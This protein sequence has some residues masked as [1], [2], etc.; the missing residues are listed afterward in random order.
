[1]QIDAFTVLLFGLFV[2]VR[3][4]RSVSRVLAQWTGARPGLRG[5]AAP[6]SSA[7]SQPFCSCFAAS[8]PSILSIGLGNVALIAA[9][10][11]CWQGA[12]AFDARAVRCGCRCWRRRVWLAACLVPGFL[13]QRRAT[14]SCCPRCCVASV[15]ALSRGRVLARPGGARCRRAGRSSC[16]S[17][18][19][20]CSSRAAFRW[21][22]CC[23]FRSARC[24]R[25]RAGVGALQSDHVLPHDAADRAARGDV[26]GA[27]RARAAHQ[28]AD[29]SADRRAQPACLHDARRP[30]AAAP[31]A[32]RTRR[33]ACCSSTSTISSRSTTG[34]GIPAATTC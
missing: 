26:E 28:G 6:S 8:P 11:C 20:R 7:A 3:A 33:C 14:A 19:S 23:R 13:E 5:G 25:S 2:K 10:A 18:A 22:T 32:R 1:M 15:L 29:R 21:S 9:F 16:C 4:G 30:A 24:R 12:R 34:S 17:R 27:A 31:S